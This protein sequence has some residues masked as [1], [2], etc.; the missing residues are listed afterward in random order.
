[1]KTAVI[2]LYDRIWKSVVWVS[3]RSKSGSYSLAITIPRRL[4]EFYNIGKGDIVVVKL[5]D[6][7]LPEEEEQPAYKKRQRLRYARQVI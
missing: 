1:M 2:S 5:V 3:G 7:I 4:A 6:I